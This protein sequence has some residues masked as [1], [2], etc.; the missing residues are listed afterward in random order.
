[1]ILHS[2]NMAISTHQ[3]Y[4]SPNTQDDSNERKFRPT[5]FARHFDGFSTLSNKKMEF[6]IDHCLS[7]SVKNHKN[8]SSHDRWYLWYRIE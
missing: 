6:K 5:E 1:M 3:L 8:G 7:V 4:Y 2:D